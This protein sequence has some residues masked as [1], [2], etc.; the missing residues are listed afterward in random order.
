MSSSGRH[1]DRRETKS[2]PYLCLMGVK[3]RE[4]FLIQNSRLMSNRSAYYQRP[5][6][7]ADFIVVG[8]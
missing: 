1:S 2:T 8:Q 5:P 3:S 7:M 4:L 6:P